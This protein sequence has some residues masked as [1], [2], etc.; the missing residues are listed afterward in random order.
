[1][2]QEY[3]PDAATP[4]WSRD[5]ALLNC[6]SFGRGWASKERCQRFMEQA[7]QYATYDDLPPELKAIYDQAVRRQ[8]RHRTPT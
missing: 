3:T 1:M 4:E 8:S 2:T 5:L 6:S 7:L